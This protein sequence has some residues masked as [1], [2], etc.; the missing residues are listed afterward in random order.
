MDEMQ[1]AVD[2]ALRAQEFLTEGN[3]YDHF[4]AKGLREKEGFE[5]D[6]RETYRRIADCKSTLVPS[7][8]FSMCS[9][10]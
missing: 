6:I 9:M 8:L 2:M 3:Y 1:H 4:F 7:P 10:I 5:D